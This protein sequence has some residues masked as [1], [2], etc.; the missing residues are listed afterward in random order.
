M[1]RGDVSVI[2]LNRRPG[3]DPRIVWKIYRVL[4]RERPDVLHTH[5]WGTLLEGLVAGRL[6]RVPVIAH[7]EHGT[8]QLRPRQIRAQRWAWRHADQLLSVSSRLAERMSQDVGFPLDRI[9]VIRN[10]V[11]LARFSGSR[12]AAARAALGAPDAGTVVLGAVGRLV[13]VKDHA[14]FIDAVHTLRTR[15]RNVFAVIAGEGPLR[16]EL[17]ERIARMGLERTVRLLGHRPDVEAVF[18][19][20][21]I[22]VQPSKSEGMSN[23]M[24]EAMASG[25]PIIA[26]AVGG[27][28][29]M[30]IDGS[31]GMLVP[32]RRRRPVNACARRSDLWG[33][34]AAGDGTGRQNACAGRVLAGS[35]GAALPVGLLRRR[36]A[37]GSTTDTR[38]HATGD[39]VVTRTPARAILFVNSWSTAHGGSSTSLIDVVTNLDS[40]RYRPIVMCPTEGELPARLRDVGIPVFVRGIHRPTREEFHRFLL[41][42]PL[43]WRWLRS[44]GIALVHGNTSASRRSIVQ[45]AVAAGVPYVQHVR[46]VVKDPQSSYAYHVAQRIVCNSDSSAAVFRSDAS[47]R[48]KTMTL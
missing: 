18:A 29:E 3:N 41:E 20:I 11:N 27:A 23:T 4:R 31:T 33:V 13:D 25:L 12:L 30:V 47:F 37:Y 6:A 45:A 35:H 40:A 42:V 38:A 1:V 5:A 10:G 17:D 28:D 7:G 19:G 24:L 21:D 9:R 46:N 39:V 44:E 26:T 43:H 36:A 34:T 14:S 2:E 22:F 15:G 8:L 16:R 48:A 32:T